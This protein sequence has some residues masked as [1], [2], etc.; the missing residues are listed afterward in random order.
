MDISIIGTGYVGLVTGACLAEMGHNV[1]CIDINKEKIENLNNGIIPIYEPGLNELVLKNIQAKKLFFTSDYSVIE[2]CEAVFSAV[3]TPSDKD[4]SADLQYVKDVAKEFAKN[5]KKHSI[6]ITKSTVPVGTGEMVRKIIGDQLK[7]L[8][9]DIEFDIVSNPEF[10]KE[11]KAVEDFLKPERIVVGVDN[12]RSKKVMEKLYKPFT[13]N[14]NNLIFTSI[15]SAEMIKYA[16][17]AML[18]TRISFMNEIANL[19]DK[20]GANIEDVRRG[21]GTDSRIG[22]KFL[23]AGCGYGGSC[24]PKDIQALIKT[25]EKEGY[26]LLIL[27]AVEQVNE[28]QK[29]VPFQKLID[30]YHEELKGKTIGLFGV[31][32]K[33]DT[34]DM[35]EA[36]SLYLMDAL[37]ACDCKIRV[38]DPIALEECRRR[39]GDKVTYCHSLYETAKDCD[40]VILV[41]EWKEYRMVDWERLRKTMKGNVIVDGRNIYNRQEVEY[42]GLIYY[43]IG[44]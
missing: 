2:F 3:G 26:P 36:P 33:P 5:I 24:F 30:H 19:C 6:F 17:N 39:V 10:L 42:N 41:T 8:D 18:A 31:S 28:R 34:D 1:H 23:Y 35:R 12:E 22:P 15:P 27:K 29:Y 40:A 44:K 16:A 14:C 7:K 20:V 25:G 32:F 43:G 21:I 9:K 4:G 11:G 13:L 38:C 37:H